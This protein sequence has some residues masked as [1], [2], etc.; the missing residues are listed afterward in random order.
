[1]TYLQDHGS[2]LV[3]LGFVTQF[4]SVRNSTSDF[5]ISVNSCNGIWWEYLT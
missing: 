2:I 5:Y 1:M 3:V 4:M